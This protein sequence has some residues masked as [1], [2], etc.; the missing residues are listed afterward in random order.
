MAKAQPKVALGDGFLQAFANIP[1]TKQKAVMNFVSKFRAN[2]RAPGINYEVIRNA[3]D[4]NFRSVRIDLDYRGI[5]LSPDQGNVYILLWVDKHDDAYTWAVRHRCQIHPT[6]GSLQL[7][8]VE[9]EIEQRET[10]SSPQNIA[11]T[12]VEEQNQSDQHTI[13][14]T[15]LFN[16]EDDILLSIG[17]P[18]ERLALVHS[19]TSEVAL[20]KIERQLPIEAFEA[21][22][23]LAAG[24]PLEEILQEYS[25]SKATEPVDIEDFEAALDNPVTQRRFH[26]PEDEQELGRMLNAP[27]ERW[28]VFLHPSQRQLVERDWNGPVRVLGG[29][30]TGKTVVA[31]HRARWL[32][33]QP[34][35]PKDARLLF[36][37]FTS[38]L[39]LD[40]A[41][42]LRKICTPEQAQ[43]IEV[44]NLDAWVSQFVKRNG[45]QST[46]VYPGGK[47]RH[48]DNCWSQAMALVPGELGLPDSFYK[49]E[50]QR[51]ILSQ[52]VRSRRD[53]F[54]ASRVGRGVALNRRQRA[55]IWPVFEEMREQLARAGFVTV[56]DAI[57]HALNLLQTGSDKRS[58]HAVVVDEGQDFSAEALSLLRAL[59][60]EQRNDL[61]IVGDAHQRIYKRKTSFSHCGINI[62]GRGRKLK[63]NY[64][65]TELIRRYATALLE[66]VEIDDLDG[67]IDS[68]NDYRS[69]VLGQEPIIKNFSDI[70]GEVQWLVQQIEQLKVEDVSLSEICLVARTNRLCEDYAQIL[71]NNGVPTHTLSRQKSDDRSQEGVRLATMHR[72]KGLEFRCV[73][74]VG[75]NK[76]IVPLSV[77]INSSQDVVERRLSDINERA[78]FHVAATRAVR[79]LYISSHG[80]PSEYL[81]IKS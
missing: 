70:G 14:A 78:L 66:D 19:L 74:M 45:Y 12:P 24:T 9:H 58:Y 65:T 35:W 59:V 22:Y 47:D 71:Q 38:N 52:Q 36:T 39:A 25:L 43:R 49:E 63:I 42:N 34:D 69:L 75:I 33:S 7:F 6:T 60:S 30:G 10:D 29:A 31:M 13:P 50:W 26:V 81:L 48:Y 23:L 64:R 27:L 18:Q 61:F 4:P 5:V 77:A 8:E 44:V 28:R 11:P 54:A 40:I 72:I 21:L 3:R 37:T 76:G 53:Y 46:I 68:T 62:R 17:V 1:R 67:G 41:D 32:V 57:H 73:M 51:V 79:Y 56:E 2:P 15:P 80:A 55:Q 20:E 16:L